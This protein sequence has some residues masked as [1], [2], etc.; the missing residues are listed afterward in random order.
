[1]LDAGSILIAEGEN[2]DEIRLDLEFKG[3]KQIGYNH[4]YIGGKV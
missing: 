1:M 3:L 4:Y 2:K